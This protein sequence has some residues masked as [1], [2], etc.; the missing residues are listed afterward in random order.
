MPGIVNIP[1][2]SGRFDNEQTEG[3]SSLVIKGSM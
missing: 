3:F 1:N 2:P